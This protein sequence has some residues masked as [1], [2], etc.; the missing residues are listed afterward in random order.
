MA[1]DTP[2]RTCNPTQVHPQR[3]PGKQVRLPVKLVASTVYPAGSLLGETGTPGTFGLTITITNVSLTSNVATV[4]TKGPHGL[5]VGDS[6][7]AVTAVTA[8]TING[9]GLTVL[10]VPTPTTFTYAKTASNVSSAADTG[11]VVRNAGTSTPKCVLPAACSTDANGVAY[12]NDS[13]ND[14][15]GTYVP[16][17]YFTGEF[18][19]SEIPNLDAVALAAMPGA[20]LLAGTITTGLVKIA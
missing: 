9:T 4:T 14:E 16:A 1:Y 19:A 12:L 3:S 8:T 6:T 15:D 5:K 7:V 11:T 10:S 13:A 2:T 18:K 17:P 20:K